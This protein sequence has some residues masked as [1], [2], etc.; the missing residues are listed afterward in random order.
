MN[1]HEYINH[2]A[3]SDSFITPGKY[4][5]AN[6]AANAN[7]V[8][9]ALSSHRTAIPL[10]WFLPTVAKRGQMMLQNAIPLQKI[11]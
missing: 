7:L 11:N 10:P 6:L 4:H 8:N 2:T 5:M 3:C 9:V 1:T